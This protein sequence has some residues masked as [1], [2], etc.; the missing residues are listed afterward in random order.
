MKVFITKYALTQGIT[1]LDAE[2]VGNGMIRTNGQFAAYFHGLGREW[3]TDRQSAIS[4]ARHMQ[5][6]KIISLEKQIDKI[7]RMEFK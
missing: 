4:A 1:E 3:H 2:E 6:L 5:A 7:R